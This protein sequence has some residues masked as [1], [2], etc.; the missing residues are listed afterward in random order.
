MKIVIIGAGSECFGRGQIADLL[1]AP[2]LQGRQ[3]ELA[4]VD[5]DGEALGIMTD[6]ARRIKAHVGA[7]ITI[8]STTERTQALP[9]ANYVITA[10]ARQRYPLWEQ[11]FRV[12]LSYGFRHCLGENGGPG[13]L[14]HALRSF[15]LI[16]PI[17]ADIER[18]CPE[19]LLLNFTNPEARVLNAILNLTRV[20]AVGICHGVFSA[21]ALIA[22]YL[23]R[24]REELDII[25][26]GMNH[27]YCVVQVKDKDTGEDLLPR[28][29]HLAA[30]DTVLRTLPLFRQMARIFGVFTFPSDD[31]IGEYLS[32]GAEFSGVKWHHGQESRAVPLHNSGQGSGLLAYASGARQVDAE[33]LCPS[34][35]ITVPII[36]DI[37]LNRHAFRDAVNVRNHEGYIENL[38]T[39]AVIEVPA[40][41][42]AAGIHPLHVGAVPE[43]FAALMRTQ[44]TIHQLLTEAYRTKSKKLLLQALLLDPNVTSITGAT[45]M[46]NDM[47]LLQ[48]EFLPTFVDDLEHEDMLGERTAC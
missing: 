40:F 7:D 24:P 11:D 42:D 4:L 26:A 29:T 23:G 20:K 10:V 41:I 43:P 12:P 8:T 18:L 46:L 14:F 45:G 15:E 13:A 16:M 34:G 28:L 2:E 30:T 6:V 22:D 17:C 36:A 33:L 32:Y 37:E 35:E 1:Q 38:P 9:G 21:L 3:V 25:S 47:L 27:F 5:V 31:H 48:Q 19:A 39:H 44:F